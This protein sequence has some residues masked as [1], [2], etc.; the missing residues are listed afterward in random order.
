[1]IIVGVFVGTLL[2]LLVCGYMVYK[3][4]LAS[5]FSNKQG[6][7]TWFSDLFT[8]SKKAPASNTNTAEVQNNIPKQESN[9]S[10]SSTSSVVV[11]KNGEKIYE[12]TNTNTNQEN[13]DT[14]CTIFEIT[15]PEFK[16]KKCYDTQTYVDLFSLIGSYKFNNLVLSSIDN[17]IDFSCNFDSNGPNC[18]YL[19]DYKEELIAKQAENTTKINNLIK[20]GE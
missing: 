4:S 7:N 20:K 15:I 11:T 5:T 1:M 2:L 8:I 3:Y 10:T 17:S 6:L 13:V 12:K 9:V 16:S 18:K 19:K 14:K